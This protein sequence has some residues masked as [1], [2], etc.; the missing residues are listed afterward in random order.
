MNNAVYKHFTTNEIKPS[1]WLKRQ[2]EIEASGLV[3]NLDKIWPDIRDSKWIGGNS[4]GW[5]RVPYW[6]D[7]FVPLAWLLDDDDMK[8]RAKKYVDGI[9]DR[10]CEDGWICPCTDQERANYDT[11]ALFI[12]AKALVVYAECS[13]DERIEEA[14]YRAFDNFKDHIRFQT[15]SRWGA[16]RWYEAFIPLA[17]LYDRRPE[18]WIK[19]L[20]RNIA[21]EGMN[22]KLLIDNFTTTDFDRNWN[23][24]VHVVNL[25]MGIKAYAVADQFMDMDGKGFAEKLLDTVRKYHGT[26]FGLFTGDECLAGISP[27]QGTELCAIVEAMYSFE[28]LFEIYGEAKWADKLEMLAF[29]ALPATVSNDMWT[30]QYDQLVNQVSCIIEPEGKTPKFTTNPSEAHIFGLEPSYGCCTANMG[31]GFPKFTLSSFFRSKNGIAA[32]AIAPAVL[33]TDINGVK[34]IIECET[35]Y[36]FK[37]GAVYTVKAD[38][39]VSFT[40]RLRVPENTENADINGVTVAP[41]DVYDFEVNGTEARAEVRFTSKTVIDERPRDMF[42]VR[43]GPLLY[44]IPIKYEK[45]MHEYVRAGVERKFPYCDYELFPKSEWRYG[46]ADDSFEPIHNEIGEYP[47]SDENPPIA[48]KAKLARI[49]WDMDKEHPDFCA[50]VPASKKAISAPEEITLYPYGCTSLRITEMPKVE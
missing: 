48:L 18:Q 28:T 8:A 38:A 16:A 29:N 44:S 49:D 13:G 37:D 11:W 15:I 10:Q 43:R 12:I 33:T 42:V 35:E 24:I 6:L 19:N 26:A 2:L 50:A 4:E 17:W 41:G 45:K 9:L 36:P 31:Q 46:L 27:T 39:P 34:V 40:L 30:H 22:Y 3:G 5:E 32:G 23:Q 21:I 14:L 25:A 20:A 7:G 1:G 47:F